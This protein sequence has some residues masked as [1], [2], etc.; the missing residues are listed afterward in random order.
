MLSSCSSKKT[1]LG[2]YS[3]YNMYILAH[4]LVCLL[5]MGPFT[6]S[7]GVLRSFANAVNKIY[8]VDFLSV[9]AIAWYK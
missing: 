1:Y 7:D 3:L 5:P 2:L 6:R 9:I 4:L 8:S